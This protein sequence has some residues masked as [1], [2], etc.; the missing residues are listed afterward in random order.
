M[1]AIVA[2]LADNTSG[3][4]SP[5]D[6]R[7]F[8]VSVRPGH[9]QLYVPNSA[10][11]AVTLAN[12]ANYYEIGTGPTFTLSSGNY[13][14]DQSSANGRL[15]Y[16]GAA[17]AVMLVKSQFTLTGTVDAQLMHFRHSLNASTV[18]ASEAR[19]W[20]TTA[21]EQRTVS[22]VSQHLV[23]NGDYVAPWVRNATATNNVTILCG[24]HTA[25]IL[26]R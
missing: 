20:H 23:T 22:F 15:T 6:V 26:P 17:D 14:V 25:L 4:I 3:A 10:A 7:D 16:T 24:T 19:Y 11:A 8:L 1:A 9:A 21:A 13:L 18:E 12:T 2:L 5:Q